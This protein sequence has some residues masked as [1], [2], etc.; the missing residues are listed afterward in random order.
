MRAHGSI[1]ILY[2]S[3]YLLLLYLDG[4]VT[5]LPSVNVVGPF[6]EGPSELGGLCIPLLLLGELRGG[7]WVGGDG[8]QVLLHV[9]DVYLRKCPFISMF[10][11]TSHAA[12]Q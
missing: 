3:L 11:L 10:T 12:G 9:C 6:V 1:N 8:E 4:H 5:F 2:R 7:D